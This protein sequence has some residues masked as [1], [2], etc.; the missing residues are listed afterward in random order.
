[1]PTVIYNVIIVERGCRNGKQKNKTTRR[2]KT[3]TRDTKYNLTNNTQ[4]SINSFDYHLSNKIHFLVIGGC[5]PQLL[6]IN[7]NINR[8]LIL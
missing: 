5:L 3:E 6:H 1:M 7:N 2:K 4:D 8:R